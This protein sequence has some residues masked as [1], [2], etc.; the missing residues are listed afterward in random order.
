MFT[1]PIG[2]LSVICV[3]Y[4]SL[5]AEDSTIYLNKHSFII[6]CLGTLAVSFFSIP[7]RDLK[8]VWNS[9]KDLFKRDADNDNVK[10]VLVSLSQ[11]KQ[12]KSG[13][14][15]MPLIQ[16]A[17]ELWEQ[18]VDRET[19]QHLLEIKLD[20]MR[21]LSQQPVIVLRNI[22]KY[23]PA[24]GMIGTVMGMISLFSNLNSENKS[25]IGLFLAVAMTATFYG[26]ILANLVILPLADRIHVRHQSV[27]NRN[28]A[29]FYALIKINNDEPSTLIKN[30]NIGQEYYEQVG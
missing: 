8:L 24:L 17:Q 29:I 19:F 5:N 14:V 13:D 12:S 7:K 6:V 18:G 25:E 22:S 2:I 4:F 9:I 27:V 26:L 15:K 21:S 3:V 28:E 11:N 30:M 23:P 10:S 16:Y 1:L 20:E